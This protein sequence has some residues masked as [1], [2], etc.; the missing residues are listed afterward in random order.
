[1]NTFSFLRGWKGRS[2]SNPQT[3]HVFKII[4]V[5]SSLYFLYLLSLHFDMP[6]IYSFYAFVSSIMY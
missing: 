1:M 3:I 5:I 6:V 2:K 4:G